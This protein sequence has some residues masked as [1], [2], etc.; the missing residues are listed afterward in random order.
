MEFFKTYLK[1]FYWGS[2][3]H[4]DG[5]LTKFHIPFLGIFHIS[6][7]KSGYAIP[8]S[9]LIFEISKCSVN[10]KQL[11]FQW[12]LNLYYLNEILESRDTIK[13]TLI[14]LNLTF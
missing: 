5:I 12:S 3:C 2:F 14:R 7:L 13:T 4:A 1:H 8:L 6:Y 10:F 9:P 11:I